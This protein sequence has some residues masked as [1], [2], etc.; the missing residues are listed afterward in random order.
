MEI[1]T[2]EKI[3]DTCDIYLGQHNDFAYNPFIRGQTTKQV[4]IVCPV[5]PN[6]TVKNV[7]CYTHLLN[8]HLGMIINVI[9]SIPNTVN[10]FFHNSDG[11]FNENHTVLLLLPNVH[12]IYTQ[13]LSITPTDRLQPLPIGIANSMWPH[14]NL[15]IWSGILTHNTHKTG[16]V[17]FNFSILTNRSARQECYDIIIKKGIINQPNKNYKDYL[18]LLRSF[19]YAICPVGNGLDTH[20]FWECLY[21][22]TVPICL[23]NTI[24]EYYSTMYPV[25]L[26][27][28]WDE[29][30][31]NKLLEYQPEWKNYN[32]LSIDAMLTSHGL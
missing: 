5:I 4:N 15:A 21:L 11:E 19:K 7:F 9:R 18:E 6:I 16:L 2:G 23:K 8:S 10:L 24:T 26:L 29:L 12:K 22:Y 3:Q 14:G 17:Y 27:D 13:N 25:Y 20:R 31:I 32:T 30:D 1:I 28:T